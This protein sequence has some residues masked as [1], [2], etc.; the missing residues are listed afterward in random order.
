MFVS[1]NHELK[2][3]W[4]QIQSHGAEVASRLAVLVDDEQMEPVVVVRRLEEGH[5]MLLEH[6]RETLVR[7][8]AHA[9]DGQ[10]RAPLLEQDG[11]DP[12]VFHTAIK[13]GGNTH[14]SIRAK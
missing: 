4:E 12:D 8:I 14:F 10:L 1:P 7:D 5:V 11:L 6:A 9:V 2:E 13:K 3:A